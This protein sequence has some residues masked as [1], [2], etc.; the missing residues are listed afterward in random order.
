V[1]GRND[2]FVRR[3]VSLPSF[4]GAALFYVFFRD[5]PT[6]VA[7]VNTAE[8][9][10]IKDRD[11]RDGPCNTQSAMMSWRELMQSR[12][13]WF[14]SLQQVFRSAGYMF[15]ASWLPSFLQQTRGVTTSESGVMQG[16]V[17][18]AALAGT[19]SGGVF[20]DSIYVRTNNKTLSRVGVGFGCMALCATMVLA[21]LFISDSKIAVLLMSIGSFL[22]AMG[23]TCAFTATIDVGGDHVPQVVAIMN[24]AG[25]AAAAICP[26]LV[27]MF[28]G[29]TNDW[30]LVLW[31]FAA[32][33]AGAAVSWIFV[34][35]EKPLE[36][37]LQR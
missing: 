2:R 3:I 6:R 18:A 26:V 13:M 31:G 32:V 12:T 24:S 19:L 4:L 33:Y 10:L 21:S 25:N 27:G 30:N 8:I 11:A 17:F 35:V 5:D 22:A 7:R 9:A 29:A 37:E 16:L 34:E 1:G 36:T 15:F 28:F 23:G 20:V 14:L